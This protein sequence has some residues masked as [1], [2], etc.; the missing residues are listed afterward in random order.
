MSKE[1]TD[2]TSLRRLSLEDL[3]SYA[4]E[5]EINNPEA[6]KKSEVIFRIMK[7]LCQK[8]QKLQTQGVIEV[9]QEGFGFLR[10]Q[11]N[12]FLPGPDDIYVPPS[13]V[14][15]N[16]LKTGVEIKVSLRKPKNNERFFSVEKI[17]EIESIIA[18]NARMVSFDNCTPLY[19]DEPLKLEIPNAP[20]KSMNNKSM[21][22]VDIVT[23][24]GK[25]QRA[26]IVAPP[27]TGKTILLQNIAQS[28]EK[29]HPD[30]H[31]IILLIDERPE[32]VTDMARTVKSLVI[33][34]T[35]D[36]PAQRHAYISE[37][38]LERAKRMAEQKK[39]V[40]IL[41]DSITRLSRAYNTITPSSGKVLTGG[42]D[43]N[44]LQKPKRF[45]GAARNIEN[46]G[47][48]TIIATALLETGSKADDVVFEEFKGTGNAEICLDRRLAQKGIY[49]AIDIARSGTR[50][51]NLLV[52]PE[53]HKKN[54]ILRRILLN[55]GG[56]EGM[57]FLLQ[58]I[59]ST[60]DNIDFYRAMNS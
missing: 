25:G 38:V 17:L 16:S 53:E 36:E 34:S 21:R 35:F 60:K 7:A 46:G 39:D 20:A 49:P 42:L 15:N 56:A 30:V 28:I 5:L 47:S 3:F 29:N 8:D 22:V 51:D 6:L 33:S 41:L 43:A 59:N 27:R 40:V 13:A 58:K 44:A 18:K 14:R 55:M 9:M 32:E 57:E 50:K 37:M 11:E 1:F 19:P 26:L 23:P 10:F 48:L 54:V 4:S 31:L 24:I 2:I 52:T 45:L 12:N